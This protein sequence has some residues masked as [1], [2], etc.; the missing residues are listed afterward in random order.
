MY[1]TAICLFDFSISSL[2][3]VSRSPACIKQ[4]IS[5]KYECFA[6]L[7][8]F[9]LSLIPQV[10]RSHM[11][12]FKR[13]A[14]LFHSLSASRSS[15]A[16]A[17]RTAGCWHAFRSRRMQQLSFGIAA[18]FVLCIRMHAAEFMN[19]VTPA[20][21]PKSLPQMS[22]SN[23]SPLSFTLFAFMSNGINSA[24]ELSARITS[25]RISGLQQLLF[26]AF[27]CML[28]SSAT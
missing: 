18:A 21:I 27:A 7:C 16:D 28:L 13:H 22:Q 11:S 8:L 15:P 20:F 3:L 24:S 12:Q 10:R 5:S 6:F 14:A 9:S 4:T 26:S 23:V 25:R 17:T 2:R 19:L 1:F